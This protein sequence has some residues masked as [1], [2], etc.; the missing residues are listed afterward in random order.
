MTAV[1]I[2]HLLICLLSEDNQNYAAS[3]LQSNERMRVASFCIVACALAARYVLVLCLA[4][5]VFSLDP[6]WAVWLGLNSDFKSL[7]YPDRAMSEYFSYD[8]VVVL[9]SFFYQRHLVTSSQFSCLSPKSQARSSL[10]KEYADFAVALLRS[11]KDEGALPPTH[12][13]KHTGSK[14][15]S[16]YGIYRQFSLNYDRISACAGLFVL[17]VASIQSVPSLPSLMVICLFTVIIAQFQISDE[18]TSTYRRKLRGACVCDHIHRFHTGRL[19]L[20]VNVIVVLSLFAFVVM[21]STILDVGSSFWGFITVLGLRFPMSL[22]VSVYLFCSLC[23]V[24]LEAHSPPTA[25]CR[26]R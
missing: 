20:C 5:G 18:K 8:F 2:V 9:V 22:F 21:Q 10:L 3:R 25:F 1:Y 13:S 17:V 23:F 14:K 7:L 11:S 26:L 15:F 24:L 19:W 6:S 4:R 12:I 16:L